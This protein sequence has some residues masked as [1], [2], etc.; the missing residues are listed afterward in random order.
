MF[1]FTFVI[2][3]HLFEYDIIRKDLQVSIDANMRGYQ[4]LTFAALIDNMKRMSLKRR[5]ADGRMN[6][7]TV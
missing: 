3:A 6:M 2:F 5:R 7:D 1:Y 4:M